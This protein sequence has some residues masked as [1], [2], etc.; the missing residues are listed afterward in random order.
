MTKAKGVQSHVGSQMKI[1]VRVCIAALGREGNKLSL[2][3]CLSE[4]KMKTKIFY[5]WLSVVVVVLL[6]VQILG[7][8]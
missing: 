1:P 2:P 3:M 5:L 8:L 4:V 6:W 7:G